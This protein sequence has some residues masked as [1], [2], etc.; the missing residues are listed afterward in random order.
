MIAPH[1]SSAIWDFETAQDNKFMN[2][3]DIEYETLLNEWNNVLNEL[4]SNGVNVVSIT[5]HTETTA[6]CLFPNNWFCT[7]SDHLTI[8]PMKAPNRRLEIREDIIQRLNYPFTYDLSPFVADDLFLEGTGSLVLDREHKIAYMSISER[9]SPQIAAAW[10]HKFNFRLILF[11]SLDSEQNIIYHTNVMMSVG[12]NY[13]IIC[14]ECIR[15]NEMKA[16]IREVIVMDTN[17]EIIEITQV[18]VNHFCGNVLE[19]GRNDN[20]ILMMSDNAFKH[21]TGEQKEKLTN[22]LGLKLVHPKVSAIETL[23]GG[24]VRC[25]IAEIF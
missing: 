24:G 22:E 7:L 10:A 16:M 12:S 3:I 11:E 6:N 19:V 23:L 9:S 25:M 2:E 18:Q 17:K 21:F 20:R 4:Q 5:N 14:M 8:F 13:V 15:G 1:I